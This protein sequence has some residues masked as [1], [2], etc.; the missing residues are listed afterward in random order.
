VTVE[1][2]ESLMQRACEERTA[3][4]QDAL[5]EDGDGS[6]LSNLYCGCVTCDVREILDAAW[7]FMY[8]LAHHPDTE[9]PALP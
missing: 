9:E 7:P 3:A 1:E 6:E 4:M 2:L 5:F 8:R